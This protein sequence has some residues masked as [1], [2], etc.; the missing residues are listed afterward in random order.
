MNNHDSHETSDFV[1]LVNG[2]KIRLYSFIS[3]LTHCMQSLDVEVFNFYK[4][5][6]NKAIKDFM[7]KFNIEYFILRFCEDLD[8]IR[9]NIFKIFIIQSAFEDFGMWFVNVKNC[10]R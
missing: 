8:K 2:N 7:T 9:R 4:H 1:K 6:H 3:H 5:W 10:I